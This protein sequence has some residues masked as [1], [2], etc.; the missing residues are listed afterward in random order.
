MADIIKKKILIVEDEVGLTEILKSFIEERRDG[1]EVY[2]AYDG[3]EG[4]RMINDLALDLII[5]DMKMPRVGGI[6]VYKHITAKDGHT[7]IPVL[8]CTARDELEDFFNDIEAAGFIN[9]PIDM[10]LMLNEV[11][12]I[13]SG[14][15]KP[16][17]FLMD[18]VD[19][20]ESRKMKTIMRKQ[21]YKIVDIRD[22]TMFR[23]AISDHRPELLIV[24]YEQKDMKG[25]EF[26]KSVRKIL[27][28]LPE[29]EE[30]LFSL[31]TLPILVYTTSDNNYK[32]KALNAGATSYMGKLESAES[33]IKIIKTA[34]LEDE[35]EREIKRIMGSSEG[36]KDK[37]KISDLGMF[38]M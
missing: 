34:L 37:P 12:R 10:G 29:D 25:E 31:K 9:K 3:E 33:F 11:D 17:I 38:G 7:K 32:E 23:T 6:E 13:I 20:G 14:K 19:R 28:S 16:I 15:E 1:Y 21:G 22:I 5:L 30:Q 8:I 4:L 27:F 26:I 36:P 2:L 35:R 24:G 18:P